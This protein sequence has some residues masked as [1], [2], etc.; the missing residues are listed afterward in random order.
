[1]IKIKD[2]NCGIVGTATHLEVKILTFTTTDKNCM[3]YYQLFQS[4][5]KEPITNQ[6]EGAEIQYEI[7]RQ[8][9]K[10]HE[11]NLNITESEFENWGNIYT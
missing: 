6:E 10:I 1:M 3:I 2:L 9:K 7:T 11:G 5:K 8:S 4:E